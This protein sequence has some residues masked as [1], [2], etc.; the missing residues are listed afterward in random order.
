MLLKIGI[1]NLRR[2]R[3]DSLYTTV[4]EQSEHE[5]NVSS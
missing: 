2:S 5:V 1:D 3:S 4:H